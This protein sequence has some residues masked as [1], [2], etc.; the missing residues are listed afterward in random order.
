MTDPVVRTERIGRVL[1]VR[2]NRPDKRNAIN[3]EMTAGLDAALNELDDD[4]DLWAGVLTGTDAFFCAGTDLANGS[5]DPTPRGGPYGVV[6]RTRRTPLIAAVEGFAYGGGFELAL[7][8]DLVVAAE[9]ATFGL[10]EVAR[11]VIATSGALFRAPRALPVNVAKEMLLV[12]RPQT[13]QRMWSFGVVNELCGT[14]EAV[15]TALTLAEAMC[16]NSPTSVRE[17]LLAIEATVSADDEAGWA[18]TA[19]GLEIVHASADLREGIDAFLN[20]RSP[21]WSGR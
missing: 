1:L 6:S 20:K 21:E 10:P 19:R 14:G 15:A 8:C 4:P 18:A 9:T 13:A 7:A 17:T 2:M 3:A 5:G 11:G 12:G 16:T